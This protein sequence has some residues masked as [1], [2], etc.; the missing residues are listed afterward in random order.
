M[1]NFHICVIRVKGGENRKDWGGRE[2]KAQT[3]PGKS[4]WCPQILKSRNQ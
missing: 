1:I 3:F 4:D 2:I